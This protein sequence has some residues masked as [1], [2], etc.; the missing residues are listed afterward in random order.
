MVGLGFI[1]VTRCSGIKHASWL[2]M[3]PSFLLAGIG[4]GL[5]NTHVR[6]T[7]TGPSRVLMHAWLLAIDMGAMLITLAINIALM[8]F[9]LVEGISSYLKKTS[10]GYHIIGLGSL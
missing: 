6:N 3:L 8:G 9:I 10:S 2:T 4:L 7:L 5:A 1:L